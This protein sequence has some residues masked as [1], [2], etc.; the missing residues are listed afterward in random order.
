[1]ERASNLMRSSG[2]ST[3]RNP[4]IKAS[5]SLTARVSC[6]RARFLGDPTDVL[7]I[8]K[9][10]FDMT[11]DERGVCQLTFHPFVIGYRSRIWV[12]EALIEHARARGDVWFATHAEVAEWVRANSPA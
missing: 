7:D 6:R 2:R 5:G 3:V 10:E 12:L 8:F 1:M 4:S 9:R 11:Y